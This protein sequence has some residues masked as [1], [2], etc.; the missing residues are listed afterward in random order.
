MS[1]TPFRG[2]GAVRPDRRG[3]DRAQPTVP[4][5]PLAVKDLVI[6]AALPVSFAVAWTLPE[7]LFRG[8]AAL[9]SPLAA[10]GLT[11][12]HRPA[13]ER[14]RRLLGDRPL[15]RPPAAVIQD[16][17]A[18]H[19]EE[20]LQVLREYRPF[21]WHPAMRLEGRAHVD[22]ALERGHGAVLWVGYFTFTGLISKKAMHWDGLLVS[23]LSHP[24]HGFSRSRLGIRY[25]NRIRARIEE[26]YLGERVMLSL[27]GAA[28]AMRTLH[29]RLRDN[30]VVSITARE[31][32]MRPSVTPFLDGT[33]RLA[34]GAA[35]LA[36]ATG[37]A[38]LPVFPVREPEGLYRVV[39]GPP[40]EVRPELAR[41]EA[42]DLALRDYAARLAP[43]VLA[44]PGQWRGWLHP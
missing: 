16:S 34:T 31:R 20:Y 28:A 35:D 42:S 6:L 19:V 29:R 36:H 2:A 32:A 17:I 39:I 21:G 9:V 18:G 43:Y 37:A 4:I 13:I 25:I 1:H 12:R 3:P 30:Q 7:P 27:D 26:R 22:A 38:L 33:I 40:L 11:T 41:R 24:T 44:Y 5:R 10:R 8:L 15:G 23:H 14:M